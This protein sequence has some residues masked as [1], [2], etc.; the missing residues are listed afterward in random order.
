MITILG[1]SFWEAIRNYGGALLI[2]LGLAQLIFGPYR[3]TAAFFIP[4]GLLIT[5]V[6]HY[7]WKRE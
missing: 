3:L 6:Q 4:G 1:G 7:A 2:G 5:I